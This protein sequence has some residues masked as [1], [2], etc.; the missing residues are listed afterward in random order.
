MKQREKVEGRN[1]PKERFINA[2]FM[3]RHNLIKVKE[4]FGERV[5]INI[6]FKDYQNK[7]SETHAD[8]ENIQMILPELYTKD[9]LEENLHD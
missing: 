5:E 8:T 4:K 2:Y 6:L 7:I 9:L 1:V 3:A